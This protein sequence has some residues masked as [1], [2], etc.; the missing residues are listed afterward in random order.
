MTMRPGFAGGALILLLLAAVG[1]PRRA[2]A[3]A[4]AEPELLFTAK[5]GEKQDLYLVHPDGTG[6][7][8]LTN[9]S[10]GNAMGVWS[11]DGKRIAFV[12]KRTGN[13]ELFLMD[14][15]GGSVKQLTT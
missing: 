12:S 11:P 7:R 2:P 10:A 9:D 8:N 3:A 13:M 14:A 15:S 4:E 6:L 5:R 1:P